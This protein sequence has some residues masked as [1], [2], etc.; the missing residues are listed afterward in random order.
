M[1]VKKGDVFVD[2]GAHI[3]CY[4]IQAAKLAKTVVTVEAHPDNF[5]ILKRN[6]ELNNFS[7]VIALNIGAW[8]SKD[9]LKL[10]ISEASGSHSFINAFGFGSIE[11]D[12]YPLDEVLIN[13]G[14]RKVDW[15]KI[16]VEGAEFEVLNGLKETLKQKPKLIIELWNSNR[17]KVLSLLS[18]YGYKISEIPEQRG[19]DFSYI[20]C[21]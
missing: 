12:T 5:S 16:D 1:K 21:S 15:I 20:F 14:I 3:G 2:V 10:N 17:D 6:I 19:D 8:S 4:T 7:N 18:S 9:K 13:F 11:I